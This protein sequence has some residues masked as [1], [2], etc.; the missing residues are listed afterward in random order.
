M[1]NILTTTPNVDA[2]AEVAQAQI[3]SLALVEQAMM[4]TA[5][6]AETLSIG[7][8]DSALIES[9]LI[10]AMTLSAIHFGILYATLT[11]RRNNIFRSEVVRTFIG[12]MLVISM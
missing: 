5:D 10:V 4:E 3:D 2:A 12:M 9:I 8:W 1:L 11:G 7:F 6:K